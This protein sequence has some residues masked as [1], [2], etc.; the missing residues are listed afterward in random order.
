V[1][2]LTQGVGGE[3]DKR[4]SSLPRM[5]DIGVPPAVEVVERDDKQLHFAV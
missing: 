4:W 5:E 2:Q 1:H 3:A